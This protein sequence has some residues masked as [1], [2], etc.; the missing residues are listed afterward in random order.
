MNG[1]NPRHAFAGSSTTVPPDPAGSTFRDSLALSWSMP[2][3]QAFGET[4]RIA[5]YN[6]VERTCWDRSQW[7]YTL[8]G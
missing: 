3:V 4:T 1:D 6:D 7:Q 8:N 5:L 2:L